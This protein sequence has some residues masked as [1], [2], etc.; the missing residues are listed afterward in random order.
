MITCATES[1]CLLESHIAEKIGAQRYK[2]WFKNATRFTIGDGFVRVDVPNIFIGEWIDRYFRG[3]IQEVAQQL[4]GETH[5]VSFSI[6]PTLAKQMRRKQPDSQRKYAAA[7]PERLARN[8]KREG[9]PPP[10]PELQG[11]LADF[12][13]G[14]SNR[15]AYTCAR[16]VI[17][18]PATQYNPLFIHGG[19]GLG[20]THLLQAVCNGLKER[21]PSL[22]WAYVSGEDFTNQFV[23]AVKAGERDAFRQRYRRLDV[24]VIDDI[25][26]F[27]N[28]RATQEEFLHTFNAIDAVGKQVVMASDAHP[29][30]IGHLS[31]SLVSRF[32]SGMV[33]RIDSP[34]YQTRAGVLRRRASRF[35]FEIPDEVVEYI[36][37]HFKANVRE[38]EG[39][40][41]KLV[42]LARLHGEALRLSL[43]Q[44][45]LGDMIE[46][47]VPVVRLTDIESVVSIYFGVTPADLHTSRKTRTIALARGTTMYLARKHTSLSFPEIGRFMGNKN[48]S[49][50]ILACRRIDNALRADEP[51]RWTTPCGIKERSLAVIVSELEEQL[52]LPHGLTK[53]AALETAKSGTEVADAA[54]SRGTAALAR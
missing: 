24:L 18:S 3:V 38:L 14:E 50:V 31:D 29:K 34:D 28:K 16:S 46:N 32:L 53:P 20:K 17:E 37:A 8:H 36:A 39:A 4:T 45:A 25:H 30:L 11:R 54:S 7:H 2:L 47:T 13:V 49:T 26:F 33:V 48:H 12:V 43:A 40:L 1:V 27:A 19:C 9:T 5:E 6:D 22:R 15:L 10:Q 35:N 52:A 23:Y 51:A 42:A 44:K 21:H 41:L